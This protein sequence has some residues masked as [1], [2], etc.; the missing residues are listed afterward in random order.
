MHV[1][2]VFLLFISFCGST[3]FQLFLKLRKNLTEKVK[4]LREWLRDIYIF[5]GV[6]SC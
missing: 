4:E 3:K 2:Y 6:D 5:K 1:D